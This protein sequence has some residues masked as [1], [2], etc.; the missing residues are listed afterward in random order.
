[1]TLLHMR[2]WV[3]ERHGQDAWQRVR[4]SLGPA[5]GA[6]VA[7]LLP[8]GWYDVRVQHRL[9]R[10]IDATL[11]NGDL[12]LV[13]SIGRHAAMHDL[14][15]IPRLFLRLATPAFVLQK[16]DDFWA[17]FYDT[18]HWDVERHDDNSA[19]AALRGFAV[20]DR[21]F[22][23]YPFAYIERT[24]RLTGVQSGSLTHPACVCRGADSCVFAGSWTV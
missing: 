24:F 9:L 12:R 22:C 2:S 15:R 17:R 20:P 1:M 6:V 4:A 14:T 10:T 23:L 8:M 19:R 18:G 5:D 7:S 3:L 11:G 16:A 13:P 21:A